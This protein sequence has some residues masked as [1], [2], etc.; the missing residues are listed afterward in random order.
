MKLAVLV[1]FFPPKLGSD[2]RIY[3]IMS[4]LSSKH[5]IHFV[6][7]P[8]FRVL[9]NNST[10]EACKLDPHLKDEEDTVRRGGIL[11]HF[12]PM[13]HALSALWKYSYVIAHLATLVLLFP[14]MIKT[15]IKINPDIVVA[16]YPSVYTGILAFSAA[17]TLRK[18]V[19]LDFNDLIAQYSAL[20]MKLDNS[21][22]KAKMFVLVQNFLVRNCH[23]VVATTGLIRDYAVNCGA[24][25]DRV[26]V[27][28]NG[29]DT[30]LFR[31]KSRNNAI[32]R[33]KLGLS[34]KKV[35]FY[36]GRFDGW[37]GI[38]IIVG[39]CKELKSKESK[40]QLL[41]VGGKLTNHEYLDNLTVIGETPFEKMPDILELA[42]AV[43]IPFPNNIVSHATSPLKLFE[44][45][46][47][48]K[49][50]IASRV[51]GI[52]E[53]IRHN[54]NGL[55]VDAPDSIG[56]WCEA[57][58]LVWESKTLAKKVAEDARNTVVERY[59]WNSLAQEYEK[60]FMGRS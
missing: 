1:E 24:R 3:E 51:D 44:G 25:Q 58:E 7:V 29:V 12:V 15:L 4:R 60:V 17:R 19:L 11:G 21:S 13:P 10:V 5:E 41:I 33:S 16:N 27:I 14:R 46:A 52:E 50:V 2:R 40:T 37:A 54:E 36:G 22:L 34:G 56:K 9:S 53:V 49:P 57:V 35:C 38:D 31:P 55:L 28:P 23:K 47:M 59:D 42:D 6:V 39:L 20:L 43:L 8:P 32:L 30:S 48:K 18:A 26:F 45:M